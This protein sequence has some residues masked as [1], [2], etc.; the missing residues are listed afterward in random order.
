[1]PFMKS[2]MQKIS[3]EHARY[4]GMLAFAN[5]IILIILVSVCFFPYVDG[6]GT[7]LLISLY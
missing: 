7:M 2:S 3:N 1:M 6:G 5:V 4:I